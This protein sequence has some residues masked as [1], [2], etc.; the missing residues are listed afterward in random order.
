MI[1]NRIILDRHADCKITAGIL[2]ESV[3]GS[4]LWN[5][6]YDGVLRIYY[7]SGVK[8]IVYADDLAVV[9][10]ANDKDNL[11][12][13]MDE[14]LWQVNTWMRDNL[15][16]ITPEKTEAVILCGKRNRKDIVFT[17][18]NTQIKSNKHL[19]Y[20]GVTVGENMHF[21]EHDGNS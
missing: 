11:V 12:Y 19:K 16:E 4:F 9:V 20:L 15:L 10:A 7:L 21:G 8:A 18:G 13:K 17:I 1:E 2:Q 3:I 6:V 5:V 14:T